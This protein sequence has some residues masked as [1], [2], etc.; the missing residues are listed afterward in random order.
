MKMKRKPELALSQLMLHEHFLVNY[1]KG[2]S[3]RRRLVS[4]GPEYHVPVQCESLARARL[5]GGGES[6]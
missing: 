5:V 6:S 1:I 4:R 2:I 3:S